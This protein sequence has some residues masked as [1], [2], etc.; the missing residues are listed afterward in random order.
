MQPK[1]FTLRVLVFLIVAVMPACTHQDQTTPIMKTGTPVIPQ[2]TA[3]ATRTQI[4][5]P[6]STPIPT[7][8]RFAISDEN[9]DQITLLKQL[10]GPMIGKIAHAVW[11]LEGERLLVMGPEGLLLVDSASLETQWVSARPDYYA[12]IN[13]G[14][15]FVTLYGDQLEIHQNTNGTLEGNLDLNGLQGDRFLVS[16]DGRALATLKNQTQ[17]NLW[18]LEKR[19]IL[20]ELDLLDSFE[21]ELE[22][23]ANLAFSKDGSRL[24]T[25]TSAGGIYQVDVE[26]GA[27]ERIFPAVFKPD[28][29]AT[30]NI[31]N[32]CHSL[33]A[34]GHSLVVLCGYYSP[35]EDYSTIERSNY[36]VRW[37]DV[38]EGKHQIQY[39]E[40]KNSYEHFSLSPD[41]ASLYMQGV[42]EFALLTKNSEG[43]Q[44]QSVPDCLNH[45]SDPFFLGPSD[46]DQLAV[47]NSYETGEM[48]TCDI[49]SGQKLVSLSFEAPSSVGVG[50][51]EGGYLVAAARCTGAIELWEPRTSQMLR[52]VHGHEGCV[53]DLAFSSDG[54]YLASGG[55]DGVVALWDLNSE[56][57]QPV[58]SYSHPDAIQDLILDHNGN[59]V[60]SISR[61][62]IQVWDAISGEMILTESLESG[63]NVTFGAVDWLAYTDGSWV[64][65]DQ[66]EGLDTEYTLDAGNLVFSPD[67]SYLGSSYFRGSKVWIYD[68]QKD[69]EFYSLDLG[70]GDI[71]SNIF[72]QDGCVLIVVHEEELISFWGTSPMVPLGR[73]ETGIERDN[74]VL[75]AGI[76]PDGR[77][78]VMG[79]QD[80]SILLWGIGGV[81]EAPLGL[82]IAQ[83]RCGAFTVP[84]P[85]PSSIPTEIP[86]QT[87]VPPTATTIAF[88]R[89]LYLT[90]PK[91]EGDDI[92][93]VQL[94]LQQL[95]YVEVGKAD[96]IFGA[97]TDQSVRNFQMDHDLEVDGIVGQKTWEK[98]FGNE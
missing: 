25:S 22:I 12:F 8:D 56:K 60:A 49:R 36:V 82:V 9:Y 86:T 47:I 90:E 53:A 4:P 23:V 87:P 31:R 20:R 65:W 17:L 83:Q 72:S 55:D 43:I 97:L 96:G 18:D 66:L 39:F 70:S 77:L 15:E 10:G 78:L 46:T 16:P 75:D 76:S 27:I 73:I 41:G 14:Q 35:S 85:T 11:S 52:S 81:L 71:L 95:G 24:F 98:L 21:Y 7:V 91:L 13:G 59:H 67:A 88:T 94:R 50:I 40:V 45:S 54:H 68:L 32:D 38:N 1:E 3:L 62:E 26:S 89:N 37:V 57:D 63:R 74:R 30:Y 33:Q 34:N 6:S 61:S 28:P 80:G 42:G 58:F 84:T 64:H 29:S 93:A 69:E 5:E 51:S 2:I 19:A 44:F 48:F 92:L 79:A